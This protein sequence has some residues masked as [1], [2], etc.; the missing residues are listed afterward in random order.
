M[1]RAREQMEY[2]TVTKLSDE[3]ES[4][5]FNRM[6]KDGWRLHIVIDTAPQKYTF[7]RPDRTKARVLTEA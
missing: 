5:L 2:K 6:E 3:S 7:S 4:D 1:D